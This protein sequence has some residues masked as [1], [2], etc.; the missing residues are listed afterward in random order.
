M[1]G[2]LPIYPKGISVIICCYNSKTRISKTLEALA[3]QDVPKYIPIEILL[4]DNCSTDGTALFSEELWNSL[5]N[6]FSFRT[7]QENTPGVAH[8][9]RRGIKESFYEYILHC[10]DDN[11]L[12]TSYLKILFE[13]F[14]QHPE[15]AAIGGCGELISDI[16]PPVWFPSVSAGYAIGPQAKTT[17]YVD[18]VYG[19]G[20][21]M[22]HSVMDLLYAGGFYCQFSGRV[23]TLK[24]VAGEDSEFCFAM[25]ITGHK[26][27]YDE[28][29]TFFHYM[30]NNRLQWEYT[31]KLFEGFYSADFYLSIYM[32]ILYK[33]EKPISPYF[34]FRQWLF[35][36][37]HYFHLL[38]KYK[39]SK[40]GDVV[41]LEFSKSKILIRE[42]PKRIFKINSIRKDIKSWQNQVIALKEKFIQE[43]PRET[44]PADI[45]AD[46]L[47]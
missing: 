10:D 12:S 21:G 27:W 4:I 3:L 6:P 41:Q 17:G 2:Q 14:S 40:P 20:M 26:I 39:N 8:A 16:P 33:V 23:G 43:H 44:L 31:R 13:L 18:A 42:L 28:R 11:F 35:Y 1:I 30:T 22:R 5:G 24:L 36:L 25:R 34:L 9:R 7:I 15:V 32:E 37:K 45:D 29:L 38:D 47:F 19:A 46:I